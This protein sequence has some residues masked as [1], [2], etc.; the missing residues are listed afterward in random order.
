MERSG[1]SLA[2]ERLGSAQP[3]RASEWEIAPPIGDGACCQDL[4]LSAREGE[5]LLFWDVD[6]E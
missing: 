5:M 1:S 6:L 3:M 2:R 4:R